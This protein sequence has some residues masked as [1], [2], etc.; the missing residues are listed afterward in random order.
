MLPKRL[1]ELSRDIRIE[2][3]VWDPWHIEKNVDL[4]AKGPSLHP[5]SVPWENDLDSPTPCFLSSKMGTQTN[6]VP[7]HWSKLLGQSKEIL[8]TNVICKL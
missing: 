1:P 6:T 8:L 4:G 3:V 5:S 7:V 2:E